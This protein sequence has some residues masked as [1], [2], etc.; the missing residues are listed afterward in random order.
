A[1]QQHLQL[2]LEGHRR[3]RFEEVGS[4]PHIHITASSG[5]VAGDGVIQ[6][7]ALQLVALASLSLVV[8][9][10]REDLLRGR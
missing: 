2:L 3:K 8:R 10:E 7:D 5:V 4:H 6:V 9:Q 1:L